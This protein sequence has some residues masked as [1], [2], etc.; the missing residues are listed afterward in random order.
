MSDAAAQP[1]R[2]AEPDRITVHQIRRHR[3]GLEQGNRIH[4]RPG[5]YPDPAQISTTSHKST[6]WRECHT[7][8]RLIFE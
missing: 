5:P 3:S 4:L 7:P 8:H 2:T 6:T 1:E